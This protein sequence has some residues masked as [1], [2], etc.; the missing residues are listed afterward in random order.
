[1]KETPILFSTTMVQAILNSKKTQTRRILKHGLGSM[2]DNPLIKV[3]ITDGGLMAHFKVHDGQPRESFFGDKCPYGKIG[4]VLW[5]REKLY[6]NGELGLEYVADGTDI[7]ENIIPEDFKVRVDKSGN[8]KFCNIP[9]I[10]M[11][12]VFARIWL[13]ITNIRVER[14]QDISEHDVIAEGI[15]KHEGGYK[16]N[17]RQP[18]SK[19]YLDGYSFDHADAFKTLWQSINGEDS[20]KL[21]PWVWVVE[22]ERINQTES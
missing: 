6:Q 16:T 5:V 18:N 12:K 13:K 2:M 20:W 21:N 10:F 9:N 22:F 1:M 15:Q 17:Y 8:Y 7:D 11:P 14:L 4:D 19:S 3:S